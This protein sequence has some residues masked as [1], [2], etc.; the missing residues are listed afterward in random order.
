MRFL[1]LLVL[2]LWGG[3]AWAH[4]AEHPMVLTVRTGCTSLQIVVFYSLQA[5]EESQEA[6][7]RADADRDGAL[8]GDERERLRESLVEIALF[9]L[10]LEVDH[11]PVS[12]PEP[13][14]AVLLGGDDA[15]DSGAELGVTLT[16][17]LTAP[18]ADG[19]PHRLELRDHHKDPKYDV[20]VKVLADPRLAWGA[21]VADMRDL[22]S[23]GQAL[24]RGDALV[25]FVA[26]GAC[27][28]TRGGPP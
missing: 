14:N 1:L 28:K 24:K 17:R 2:A 21:P 5:G 19:A 8:S 15:T 12:L 11:A 10:R 4:T 23:T 22:A 27:D 20:P 18:W 6:R 25:L 13:A 7:Q 26:P 3:T 9:S 16:L